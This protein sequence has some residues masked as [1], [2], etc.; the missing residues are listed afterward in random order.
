MHGM[1]CWSC[2]YQ[3]DHHPLPGRQAGCI[4]VCGLARETFDGRCFSCTALRFG[5]YHLLV[6][7]PCTK[8]NQCTSTKT[9]SRL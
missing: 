1:N 5:T 4:Y 8:T 6:L 9:K 7:G 2:S 3:F